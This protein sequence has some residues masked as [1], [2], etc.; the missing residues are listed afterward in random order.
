MVTIWPVGLSLKGRAMSISITIE[1]GLAQWIKV[2]QQRNHASTEWLHSPEN[3]GLLIMLFITLCQGNFTSMSIFLPC[4]LPTSYFPDHH[5]FLNLTP[6]DRTHHSGRP[7][8]TYLEHGHTCFWAWVLLL[9]HYVWLHMF[10]SHFL[11]D[12]KEWFY[13]MISESLLTL[14]CR[15][16]LLGI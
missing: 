15:N 14:T 3:S 1:Q 2:S 11:L 16:P 8:Q 13:S 10:G 6:Q 5:L 4:F 7:F 12:K 9:T